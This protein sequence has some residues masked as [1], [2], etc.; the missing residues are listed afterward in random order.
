MKNILFFFLLLLP[1][2][3]AAQSLLTDT[4]YVSNVNG[5]FY[6]ISRYDYTDGTY[7]ERSQRIG[8]T[9]DFYRVALQR[10][11]SEARD[12]ANRVMG[13]INYSR[14]ISSAIREN[15]GIIA[16]TGK[17]PLDTLEKR[18]EAHLID[19]GATW[20]MIAPTGNASVA[21]SVTAAG[22]LRYSID[23]ATPRAVAAAFDRYVMRLAAYPVA[24]QSLDLYWDE[25]RNRY[26]SQDGKIIIRKIVA[27]R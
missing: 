8:D 27:R 11:E 25:G 10:F 7:A 15:A 6:L 24:G 23:G 4:A 2:L 19:D 21:F 12:N 26:V 20:A 5:I 17:S 13:Y 16:V 1:C 22:Q 14:E 18:A 3:A 9:S